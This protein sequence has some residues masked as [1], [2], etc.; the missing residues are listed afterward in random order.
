[1]T[2]NR[3][4][5]VSTIELAQRLGETPRTVQRKA[6]SGEY[7][8]QKLPGAKGAYIFDPITVERLLEERAS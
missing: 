5:M 6:R 2:E 8:A 7:P 3:Q 4:K 1:M